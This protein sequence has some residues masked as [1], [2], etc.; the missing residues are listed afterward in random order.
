MLIGV[1]AVVSPRRAALVAVGMSGLLYELAFFFIAPSADFRYSHWLVLST[2]ALLAALVAEILR[3]PTRKR[4]SRAV[5][6]T[7]SLDT[8]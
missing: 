6:N 1:A 8:V 2:W 5:Q 4:V 7:Q 3:K